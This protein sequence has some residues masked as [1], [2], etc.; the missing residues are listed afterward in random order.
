MFPNYLKM[1]R[2]RFRINTKHTAPNRYYPSFL[3]GKKRE[4]NTLLISGF[5]DH[6]CLAIMHRRQYSHH[7]RLSQPLDSSESHFL[8]EIKECVDDNVSSLSCK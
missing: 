3:Y 6:L 5:R 8:M 7:C 2:D 1:Y 4:C